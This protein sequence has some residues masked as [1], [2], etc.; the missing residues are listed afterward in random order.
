MPEPT[1]VRQL[2]WDT[3]KEKSSAFGERTIAAMFAGTDTS[4]IESEEY[5]WDDVGVL[6]DVVEN[7][8][9]AEVATTLT[10]ISSALFLEC[11]PYIAAWIKDHRTALRTLTDQWYFE[12]G[13]DMVERCFWAFYNWRWHEPSHRSDTSSDRYSVEGYDSSSDDHYEEGNALLTL[14]RLRSSESSSSADATVG[15]IEDSTS[16]QRTDIVVDSGAVV[17]CAPKWFG[18]CPRQPVQTA[19]KLR[20]VTASGKRLGTSVVAE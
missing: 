16:L 1:T 2:V 14:F 6:T 11:W 7:D 18:D 19:E 9:E 20:L 5:G 15:M 12:R 13:A 8:E 17:S 3:T 4:T 10:P